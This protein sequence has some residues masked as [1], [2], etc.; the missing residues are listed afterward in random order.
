[1]ADSDVLCNIVNLVIVDLE[2]VQRSGNPRGWELG[3]SL[4][5]KTSVFG[6]PPGS[7][8]LSFSDIGLNPTSNTI[9][10]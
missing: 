5:C 3:P 9:R 2:K 7:D 4:A 6:D 8:Q 1:M 10:Q